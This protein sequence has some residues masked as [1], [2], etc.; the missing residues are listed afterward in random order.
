MKSA[1]FILNASAGRGRG[2]KLRPRLKQATRDLGWDARIHETTHSG[3][4]RELAAQQVNG[5]GIV[6]ANIEDHFTFLVTE[7]LC[8]IGQLSHVLVGQGVNG[9]ECSKAF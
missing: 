6:F 9:N 1:F 2:H 3:H 8:G 5:I 4:E 7:D